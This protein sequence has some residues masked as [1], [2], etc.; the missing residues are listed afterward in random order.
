MVGDGIYA[1]G[2][3]LLLDKAVWLVG[4]NGAA[5]TVIDGGDRCRC[6]TLSNAQARVEG[7]TL[8]NGRAAR[9]HGGGVAMYGGGVLRECVV[10]QCWAEQYGGG[11]YIYGTGMVEQCTLA[12]N[13]A[14]YGGGVS[15]RLFHAGPVSSRGLPFASPGLPGAQPFAVWPVWYPAARNASQTVLNCAGKKDT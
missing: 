6:V 2:S 11:V 7:F 8:V 15:V 9:G 10:R 3:A 12:S 14:Y 13:T 5:Y 4:Y 1:V